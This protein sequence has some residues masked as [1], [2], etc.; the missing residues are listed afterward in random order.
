MEVENG[1]LDDYSST[2]RW[3]SIPCDV[4]VRGNSSAGTSSGLSCYFLP[5][6][7]TEH[8][9]NKTEHEDFS[10]YFFHT[11]S[12]LSWVVSL[13]LAACSELSDANGRC[14]FI[15]LLRQ[16]LNNM[17]LLPASGV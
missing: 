4:F 13:A 3:F 8:L 10:A 14:A 9:S 2:N 17:Q 15:V 7:F 12:S 1:P 5:Y 11:F 6:P 16:A